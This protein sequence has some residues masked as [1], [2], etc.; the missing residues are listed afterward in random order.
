MIELLIALVIIGILATIAMVT[1]NRAKERALLAR[2][3]SNVGEIELSLDDYQSDHCGLYP[4]LTVYH[5]ALPASGNLTTNPGPPGD[6]DPNE[7]QVLKR[8]GNA[9]IGGGPKLIDTGDPLQD[10]F[11]KDEDDYAISYFRNRQG[12][13]AF[14]EPMTP[15][16]E[17]VLGGHVDA[18]PENPLKGPGTPMV[19]IAYMLYDY[20]SQ[21]N[22]FQWVE[23][24]V[25][26]ANSEVRTGLCAARP[27]AEGVYEPISVIWDE[28]TYPQG[29]FAYIPFEF[30]TEQGK[31][32][33]GYWII[34]YG[35]LTT[36][37]T[38]EYNK[39]AL[40]SDLTP[41]DPGPDYANWPNLPW[42]YGDGVPTTPPVQGTVEFEIKRLI[43]GALDVR[44]TVFEDQFQKVG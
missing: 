8:M 7:P 24:T 35:D 34:C 40:R 27:A 19:N 30:S 43:Q 36:L 17:L 11:Y 1:F 28:V 20:D 32:C 9:L 2:V 41:F 15:V 21:T 23:M 26:P 14:G 18:Y 37:K 33:K 12:E 4:A 6:P 25:A 3:K 22:D 13:R 42:P 10:D 31:Y 29:D 16:D 38:S 5:S 39:F 44:H